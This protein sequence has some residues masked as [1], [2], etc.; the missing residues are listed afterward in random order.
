MVIRSTGN[1]QGDDSDGDDTTI[2]GREDD[3]FWLLDVAS[4]SWQEL[5][6]DF[7]F[8]NCPSYA[9]DS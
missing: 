4:G 3:V 2:E 5:Y 7:G 9:D 6:P 8:L 1:S